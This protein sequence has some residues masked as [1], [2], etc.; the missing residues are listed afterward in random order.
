MIIIFIKA[1]LGM[2]NNDLHH[3]IEEETEAQKDCSLYKVI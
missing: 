2:N 3:F 1:S